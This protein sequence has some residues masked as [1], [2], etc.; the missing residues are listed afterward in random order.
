MIA[1]SPHR[2]KMSFKALVN[3]AVA[4]RRFRY[5]L[6]RLSAYPAFD[7]LFDIVANRLGPGLRHICELGFVPDLVIDVGAHAGH[8]TIAARRHFPKARFLM[9]EAQ[10]EKE[11]SLRKVAQTAPG[12]IEYALA[13]LGPEPR[14]TVEFYLCDT[15]SSLYQEQTSFSRQATK[16][17]MTTLDAVA[18]KAM[19][20]SGPILLNLDVQGAELDVL[21]GGTA[22]LDR[23]EVVILEASIVAYNA[24]APRVAAVIAQ[25]ASLGF[26]L[27]DVIDLRR[28]QPVLAQL[29]L[30]FVRAG[31]RLEASAAAIIRHYGSD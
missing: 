18:G 25:L 29:D 14:E 2:W 7:P 10:L 24:G 4:G 30:V 3:R 5:Y 9:I 11:P 12:R 27:F 17:A 31:G 21:A 6:S 26:N 19:A 23:A 22:V 28:I 15:G 1:Q 8:W 16:M 13:P 20:E